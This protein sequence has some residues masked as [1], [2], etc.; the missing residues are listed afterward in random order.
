MDC[1]EL[2]TGA[3]SKLGEL[4]V[5]SALKQFK[6][7]IQH[8]KIIAN[9]KEELEKLNSL[10]QSLQGWVDAESTKGNAIPPNLSNWLSSVAAIEVEL[11][12]FYE[13][14]DNKNKKCF[15]GQ[16]SDLAL[17]YSQGKQATAKTGDIT[18]LKEEGSKLPL[19]SYP[20]APPALGSTFLKDIKSLESRNKIIITV[21]EKLNDEQFKRISICGMG[22]VG[23]T[24]LVKELIKIVEN[25]L[26][27]K[28]VMAVIS[29]NPDYDK[30]QRKIA[31]DLGLV[32][33]RQSVEGRGSEILER[34]KEFNDKK[35]KVLIVLDDVWE[36]LNFEWIGLS[37]QE[38]QQAIKILF[39]SRN[40]EVCQKMGSQENVQVSVLLENE[41]WSLFQEMAGGIVNKH[42]INPIAR[43]IAKQCAGLP[44]AIATIGR[45]LRKKEKISWEAALQKLR[46]SQASSFPDMQEYVY[47]RIELS[48]NFLGS[49]EHKSCLFLCGLFPEDF[50]IPIES[51]LRHGVGLGLFDATDAVWEARNLV[52]DMVNSLKRCFLLLDS[53]E[54]G[55]IKMHDVVRDVVLKISFREELGILVQSNSDLKVVKQRQEKCHRM[56]LILNEKIQLESDLECPT[57]E[58]LQ[59]Q[60]QREDGERT[61]WP[62]NFIHGM[63][64]LKVLYMQNLR[65]P[66]TSPHFHASVNTSVNLHTLLL[67]GCDVGDIS[68][69]GKEVKKLEIL[70]FAYSN[71]KELPAEIGNLGFLKLLDLT[72]CYYLYFISPNV[73][74][75]LSK[76]EELYFRT[77][78]F[79]RLQNQEF[80]EELRY[81]SHLKVFEIRVSMLKILPNDLIFKNL[82]KFWIYAD[83]Y[84]SYDRYGY[85]ELNVIHLTD[86]DYNSIKSS[87][88]TMHLIKKCELLILEEVVD[89]KNVISELDDCGLQYVN[90]LRI[91]SCPNLECV[92]DCNT[93]WRAF[94]L[95]KSLSLIKLPKLREIIRAHDHSETNKAVIEF[96][97][98]EKLEL[99]F[100]GSLIGFSNSLYSDEHR[101]PIHGLSSTTKLTDSTNTEDHEILHRSDSDRFGCM[102]SSISA[103]LFSSNW[104]KQ[105]PKLE[106]I[107]L[108]DCSSLEMI[109]DLEECSESSG[110]APDCCLFP[111]LRKLEISYIFKLSYVWGNVPCCVQGFHNLRF[112][113]ISN[114]DSLKYVFTSN[115]VRVITNLEELKVISCGMIE[116]IVV[117]STDDKEDA[118]VNGHATTIGFNKLSY[119]SLSELPKLINVCSDSLEF[120]CP[121]LTKFEIIECPMLEIS[122]LPPHIQTNQDNI[123][124]TYSENNS[125]SSTW[126]LP[127]CR[128]FLP[129][130]IRQRT[131]RVNKEVSLPRA[132]ED[133]IPYI[134][135]RK[136][137]KVKKIHMPV[138]EELCIIKCDLLDVLFIFEE[139]FNFLVPSHLQTIRI[140]KCAKL[141]VIM[142]RREERDDIINTFTRLKS[143]HLKELPNLV[144]FSF[145]GIY[146]SWDKQDMDG[147][148]G[149]HVRITCHPL[150]DESL[151]P[152]ITSLCIEACHKINILFSHSSMSGLKHL[153]KLKVRDCANMEEI[154]LHQGKI[155]ASS[156]KI[157]FHALQ[158]LLLT[159]L[160]NLKAFSQC[161]NNLDFPSLQNVYIKDCPNMEVFSRGFSDT[162]KLEDLSITPKFEDLSKFEHH[163]LRIVS[164]TNNFRHNR[165]INAYLKSIYGIITRIQ[166]VQLDQTS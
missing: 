45:A 56:S 15:G 140:E 77:D 25:K 1:T 59:V 98:L 152:N 154:V 110:D 94:P 156:S 49:V 12:S 131:K 55:C 16:C 150:M 130:F 18:R 40:E 37:S 132:L 160:P 9:L 13:N 24:T 26:F 143:L 115:I 21:I 91:E 136:N 39:T 44:L 41:A 105:F 109:F 147:Q 124:V 112:L 157:V 8:K 48:F 70:S 7:M 101:Q 113:T 43:E 63:T 52:N 29:L 30:I 84:D 42:D 95:I 38:H 3:I 102:P 27:D 141:K 33:N 2:S 125:S 134:S 151:F 82:E 162:P 61:S 75:R 159:K 155:E 164:A 68:I 65:I 148:E 165:D 145:S 36:E 58:L 22:G 32:L 67:E 54:P 96:S 135:E 129:K 163:M 53:E 51:L 31:D 92:V 116:N 19:I 107:L 69:I 80:L 89:L 119:L 120:Q 93:P 111:Q 90:H 126:A 20:K 87:M 123:I 66:K 71:I 139:K 144:R 64:K 138:L 158:Y 5:K 23:K 106:T 86:L 57:L 122:L 103:K 60:S 62:E 35:V 10:K 6:Y 81:L 85:L 142:A 100:L 114:C 74:A 127:G 11:Q 166:D 153:Q 149:D 117:W 104:M 14:R 128:S 108:K 121:S 73:F 83:P 88:M 17:K 28:V 4:G 133:R 47:S 161:H 46:H 34:L 146:E 118:N 99:Q 72:G 50:D 78:T 137:K 76:L 97:N 79:S